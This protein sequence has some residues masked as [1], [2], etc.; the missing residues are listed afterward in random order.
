MIDWLKDLFIRPNWS[1]ESFS[2]QQGAEIEARDNKGWTTLFYATYAGHQ[3][4]VQFLLENGAN[5]NAR[6]GRVAILC[7]HQ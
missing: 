6:Y 4:M 2:I 1:I 3:K 7:I 5:V